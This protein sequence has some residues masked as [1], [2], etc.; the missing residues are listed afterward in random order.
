MYCLCMY[1]NFMKTHHYNTIFM[2]FR[3]CVFLTI[4]ANLA[5]A[6][7]VEKNP[8]AAQTMKAGVKEQ[9]IS[10]H[11]DKSSNNPIGVQILTPDASVEKHKT[12]DDCSSNET[13]KTH[14]HHKSAAPNTDLQL[15]EEGKFWSKHVENLLP[16]GKLR[17]VFFFAPR[18]WF[19]CTTNHDYIVQ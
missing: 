5:F 15:V 11:I 10:Y 19:S 12:E 3:L 9:N 7:F 14:Q 8:Q 2:M 16:E 13:C 17:N 4:A 6:N 18:N 1:F